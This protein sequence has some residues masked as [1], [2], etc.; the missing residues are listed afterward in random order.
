M[1]HL[2]LFESFDITIDDILIEYIENNKCI[3]IGDSNCWS[4]RF[5]NE[6]D[7]MNAYDRLSK[8]NFE[9]KILNA[10]GYKTLLFP[11]EP[12]ISYL[13]SFGFHSKYGFYSKN[14]R[15]YYVNSGILTHLRLSL[16]P[17]NIQIIL[18]WYVTSYI[19]P[20]VLEILPIH[21]DNIPDLK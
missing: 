17:I 9:A 6:T 20:N 18:L 8:F 4:W 14:R 11:S 21:P 16:S 2:K 19:E 7:L 3:K 5:K 12:I 1:R 15:S 10:G 13:D